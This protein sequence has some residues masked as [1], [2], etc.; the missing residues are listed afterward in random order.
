MG[1]TGPHCGPGTVGWGSQWG[2]GADGLLAFSSIPWPWA[3]SSPSGHMVALVLGDCSR[4]GPGLQRAGSCRGVVAFQDVALE[5]MR[6]RLCQQPVGSLPRLQG[7]E[8][9]PSSGM[10]GAVF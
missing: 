3:C 6:H 5:V 8:P 9:R 4:G 2:A 10:M 7:R 1:C